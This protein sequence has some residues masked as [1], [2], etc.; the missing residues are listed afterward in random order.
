MDPGTTHKN[1]FTFEVTQG[2]GEANKALDEQIGGSHYKDFK[3]QPL[4]FFMVNSIPFAEASVIKYVCRWRKKNGV[5]DLKKA[6]HLLDVMIE[7]ELNDL[8]QK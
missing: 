2:Q 6:R 4:E 7:H 5:E 8:S 1:M 3:I